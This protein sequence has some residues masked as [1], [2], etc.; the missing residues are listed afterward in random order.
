MSYTF[1]VT[2]FGN[3]A[4]LSRPPALFCIGATIT[5]IFTFVTQLYYSRQ[6]YVIS[7]RKKL[8][9]IVIITLALVSF[10]AL[11]SELFQAVCS[12]LTPRTDCY[13]LCYS[14]HDYFDRQRLLVWRFPQ[15]R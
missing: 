5:G 2:N 13:G 9:P 12:G 11:S 6:V 14:F 1:T 3:Y 7:S 8:L 10:G 15:I 4:N